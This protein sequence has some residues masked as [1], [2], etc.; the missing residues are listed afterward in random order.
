MT[1]LFLSIIIAVLGSLFIIG[2]GLDKLVADQT[3]TEESPEIVIYKKLLEGFSQQLGSV[4]QSELVATTENMAN[5]YQV[6]VTLDTISNVALPETLLEQ[7]S[8]SGGLLLATDQQTY[9]LRKIPFHD[10]QLLKLELP[11]TLEE[12]QHL[13][14]AL[15]ALLYLGVCAILILWLFPLARRLFI[16]TNAAA[17]IGKGELNVRVAI[18]QFSYISPLEKSFNQMAA[19]I[20]KLMADNKLLA[21]SL[22]HDIR[23]PM[24][25]LRFGVEAALD[26][27]DIEKKDNYLIRIEKELTNMEAMTSAF[28][29]YAGMERQGIHL[30]LDTVDINQFTSDICQDFQCLAK[31]HN[32]SLTCQLLEQS[33]TYPLDCHWFHRALQNLI[34]NAVQYANTQVKINLIASI[35][36][37]K[38]IIEDDG[39]GLVQNKLDVIFDPF[40]K[41]D[42]N[43][44]REQGHFGLGLAIC[45]KV[46]HWHKGEISAKNS[47][48]FSGACFT[49]TLPR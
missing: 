49:I 27:Q 45:Q 48:Q 12:N 46:V 17:K 31:Q 3:H 43:R 26:C 11:V 18:N 24:S 1:R 25:C 22:S 33:L 32:I 21:R 42:T 2:W 36:H 5:N 35:D 44:S 4:A 34:S 20:E 29:S 19:Q 39:I 8:Q 38:F 47:Q 28:L 9:L 7:L 14:I 23:T 15:T 6:A 41:L 13:S 30:K 40:V 10:E 16:L 37:L